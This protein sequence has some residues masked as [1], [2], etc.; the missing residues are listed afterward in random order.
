MIRGNEPTH[1]EMLT[2]RCSPEGLRTWD[3]VDRCNQDHI[4]P[5]LEEDRV[6]YKSPPPRTDF[7]SA[8][9]FQL[10][11]IAYNECQESRSLKNKRSKIDI[12]GFVDGKRTFKC[13][14][15]FSRKVACSMSKSPELFVKDH[16]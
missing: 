1:Q 16:S 6:G 11:H 7:Q 10:A 9:E 3:D 12:P 5:E 13:A 14:S 15:C 2:F 8:G 4:L